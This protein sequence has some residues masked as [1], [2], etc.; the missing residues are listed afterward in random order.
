[1]LRQKITAL[2]VTEM[3]SRSFML[4]LALAASVPPA[5][6]Q[7]PPLGGATQPEQPAKSTATASAGSLTVEAANADLKAARAANQEKRFADAEALMLRDTAAKPNMTY[8]WIELGLAQL[9]LKKYPD[10]EAS[11]N[12]ALSHGGTAQKQPPAG[13]FYQADG[14][15]AAHVAVSTSAP[16]P[17]PKSKSEIEGMSYSSL[18]EVY[19]RTNRVPE[20]KDA[21]D[22]AVKANPAQAPLY[23][24]NETIFFLQMGNAVEQVI[25]ADKAIAVDP[26]R[27]ALYFFKGQGLA[28][29]ATIDPKTQKLILPASCAEALQKYL[30]L[31]PT[32]QYSADAKGMLTAAGVPIKSG[33]K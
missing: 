10:A 7:L 27:A 25:A 31:D 5:V 6:A 4:F 15:T 24:R 9:G 11:F 26:T 8:L 17:D 33:K 21:Y 12:A 28:A 2:G 32:G 16:P 1:L 23:L 14:R 13:G 18:G 20:A 29:Q 30:D 22:K 19:I 3:K